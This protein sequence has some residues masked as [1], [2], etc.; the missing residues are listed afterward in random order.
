MKRQIKYRILAVFLLLAL[1]LAGCQ[2][3]DTQVMVSA[4]FSDNDVFLSLIHI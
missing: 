3:G 2:L 1:Q 4:G